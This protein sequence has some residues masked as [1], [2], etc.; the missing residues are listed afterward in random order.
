MLAAV[1]KGPSELLK[2]LA[3]Q[4]TKDS[5]QRAFTIACGSV[6]HSNLASLGIP[7]PTAVSISE[8]IDA[9]SILEL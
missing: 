3:S 2:V 5:S 1:R 6:C 9:K 8:Q 7:E 4:M